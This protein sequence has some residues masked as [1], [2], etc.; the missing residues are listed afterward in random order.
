MSSR[1]T[2]AAAA[3]SPCMAVV[4]PGSPPVVDGDGRGSRAAVSLASS[5]PGR[6]LPHTEARETRRVGAAISPGEKWPHVPGTGK[7]SV[8]VTP[9]GARGVRA[10][11]R[12]RPETGRAASSP[13]LPGREP[14]TAAP[15]EEAPRSIRVPC[16][17]W[18][19]LSAVR[20]EKPICQRNSESPVQCLLH[21]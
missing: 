9:V 15:W 5:R 13:W 2:P 14:S 16:P 10:A 11:T 7:S 18:W 12:P 6:C 19:L 8:T 1:C 20:S 4:L 3:R 17:N 21:K